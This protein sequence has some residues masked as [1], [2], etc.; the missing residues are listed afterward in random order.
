MLFFDEIYLN[1][2][3]GWL[4][5]SLNFWIRSRAVGQWHRLHVRFP[6]VENVYFQVWLLALELFQDRRKNPSI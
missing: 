6:T 3:L 5:P 4:L 2:G 1:R